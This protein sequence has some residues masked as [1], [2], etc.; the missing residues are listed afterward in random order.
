MLNWC[1]TSNPLRHLHPQYRWAPVL[2]TVVLAVNAGAALA[3]NL[4]VVR[5]LAGR[6]GPIVG[7]AQA[8]QGVA[9]PRIQLI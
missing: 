7:S 2:L 3:D 5:E 4:K 8:C 9:R 1:F 6:V